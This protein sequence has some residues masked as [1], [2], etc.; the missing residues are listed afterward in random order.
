MKFTQ[1]DLPSLF[2]VLT[3]ATHKFPASLPFLGE[4]SSLWLSVRDIHG[5]V[6]Q[7]SSSVWCRHPAENI[8]TVVEMISLSLSLSLGFSRWTMG[9]TLTPVILQ[10]GI[11]PGSEKGRKIICHLPFN[12]LL[13][14]KG[15]PCGLLMHSTEYRLEGSPQI[16]WVVD[17]IS[18][19]TFLRSI[20]I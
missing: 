4:V 3:N 1:V 2:W 7:L 20:L 5:A 17:N 11:L 18:L 12:A 15:E 10:E 8:P 9:I 6:Q 19:T 13:L 14:S 16:R